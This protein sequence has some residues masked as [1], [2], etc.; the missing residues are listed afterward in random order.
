MLASHCSHQSL[1]LWHEAAV[2]WW[3]RAENSHSKKRKK[4]FF[5]YIDILCQVMTPLSFL[6]AHMNVGNWTGLLG[7]SSHR[8][9]NTGNRKLPPIHFL[10]G[11][12]RL[13]KNCVFSCMATSLIQS[14]CSKTQRG[15]QRWCL[16][17][18]SRLCFICQRLSTR[19]LEFSVAQLESGLITDNICAFGLS[20]AALNIVWQTGTHMK[21]YHDTHYSASL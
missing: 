1:V 5:Y 10:I 20:A 4:V 19:R 9:G 21:Q 13:Q 12:N 18:T 17:F 16:T 15:R 2:G 3:L 11:W 7:L 6:E 14:R 8:L